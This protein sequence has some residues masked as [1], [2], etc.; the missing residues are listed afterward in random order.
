[1]ALDDQDCVAI[2][3]ILFIF[4]KILVSLFIWWRCEA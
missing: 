4:F 3:R 1:M 2:D